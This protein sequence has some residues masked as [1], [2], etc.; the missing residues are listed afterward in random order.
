M[1]K[2]LLLFSSNSFLV[3]SQLSYRQHRVFIARSYS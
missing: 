1:Q 3:K 2:G